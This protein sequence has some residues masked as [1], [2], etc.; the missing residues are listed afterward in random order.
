MNKTAKATIGTVIGAIIGALIYQL[1][2][3]F[4]FTPPSFDEQLM[5]AAEEINKNCPFMVDQDTRLDN[6][7][8]GPGKLFI[9]NYTLINW[10]EE[11]LNKDELKEYIRPIL[12]NNMI[13]SEDMRSF[14]E[15]RVS[16][17]Y[18]YKDKLGVHLFSVTID[19]SDY[20][21]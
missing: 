14:R 15:N 8:A 1:T 2:V 7:I 4:I 18:N 6:A 20:G 17:K 19:P 9:Y 16:L 11:E 12:I 21:Y 5:K 13:T 10:V 3:N